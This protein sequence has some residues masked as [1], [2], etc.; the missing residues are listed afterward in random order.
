IVD[1]RPYKGKDDLVKKN[2][3][4][5]ATYDKIKNQIIAKQK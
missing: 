2:V 5:K 3:V 4:P 1:A